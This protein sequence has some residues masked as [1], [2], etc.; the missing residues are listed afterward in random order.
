MSNFDWNDAYTGDAKDC[1]EPDALVLE[2]ARGLEPGR[3]LDVGCGAGGL[4]ASLAELGWRV[5]G[6]DIAYK[7]IE[8]AKKALQQRGVEATLE[9]ADA[10]RWKPPRPFDL[11][12]CCFALPIGPEQRAAAYRT[13][14]D[15]V[16]PG[17]TVV[18]KDF[19][20]A[21]ARLGF[22]AENELVTVEELTTAFDGFEIVR[23]EVVQTPAHHHGD[24]EPS[25]EAWSA[26]LLHARRP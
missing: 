22:L 19:D 16:A 17:G 3:A 4:L 7:A 2:I 15:A 11:V 5:S 26:G 18:V 14:R 23:A 6:I 1:A 20:T 10:T 25:K 13:M 12:T 21:M 8:A 24:G 9:A